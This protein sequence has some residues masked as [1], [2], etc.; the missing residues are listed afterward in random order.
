MN[1]KGGHVTLE[2]LANYTTFW[3][4]PETLEDFSSSRY[5]V[6][7]SQL[8]ASGQLLEFILRTMAGT[9]IVHS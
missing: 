7:S 2:D 1:L 9:D 3:T 4:T 6:Y 8:T 5:T